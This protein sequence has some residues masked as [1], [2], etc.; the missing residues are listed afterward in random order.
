MDE[1]TYY[2]STFQRTLIPYIHMN[3]PGILSSPGKWGWD[4]PGS[5]QWN[6]FLSD[7]H[8]S[9]KEGETRLPKRYYL[10]EQEAK[11]AFRRMLWAYHKDRDIFHLR[12]DTGHFQIYHLRVNPD[13]I[14]NQIF[15]HSPEAYA[16]IME[17]E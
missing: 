2:S 15:K 8:H 4:T 10:D 9:L 6:E 5:P 1:Y 11:E 14:L 16:K 17:R 13:R 3:N 12:H 7:S